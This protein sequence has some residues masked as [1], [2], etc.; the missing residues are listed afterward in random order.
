MYKH[1]RSTKRYKFNFARVEITATA[2]IDRLRRIVEAIHTKFTEQT[3]VVLE[4]P[5]PRRYST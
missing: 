4:N 2:S 5:V 1:K 3:F